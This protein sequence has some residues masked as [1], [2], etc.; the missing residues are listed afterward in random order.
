MSIDVAGAIRSLEAT[1]AAMQAL[2]ADLSTADARW[3]PSFDRWSILEVVN[4]L[5]D[6]EVED[7]RARLDILLHRPEADFVPIDPPGAVVTRRYSERELNESI[8]RF[9]N[10]RTISLEWLRSLESP[11]LDRTKKDDWLGQMSG[12]QM[13]ASWVAHDLHHVRQITRLRYERLSQQVAPI[14]LVYAGEW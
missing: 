2:V 5:V 8:A 6:E 10:E 1:G 13:L 3:K 12:R 9:A 4:H 7:F 11:N 14:T